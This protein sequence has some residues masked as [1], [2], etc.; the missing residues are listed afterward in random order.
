MIT[1]KFFGG[2]KKSFLTD[3]LQLKLNEIT[4]QDLIEYLKK[5]KPKNGLELEFH[6]IIFAVNGIDSSVLDGPKTI[7]KNNDVVSIIPI[8]HG[9]SARIQFKESGRYVELF[10]LQIHQKI[11][12][13][14]LDSLRKKFPKLLLQVISS[15]YILNKNHARKVITTS[16]TYKKKR[17]LLSKKLETDI[18]LRFACTRQISGAIVRAGIHKQGNY[19]IIAIGTKPQLAGLYQQLK[20][21]SSEIQYADPKLIQKQFGINAIQISSINSQSPIEDLLVE[22]AAVLF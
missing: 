4:I 13:K 18:L 16:F 5:S 3:I 21:I 22:K 20:G 17:L 14:I 10:G 2:A 8:I 15:Q 6:N 19:I 12:P 11:N 1:I 7:L 9:G